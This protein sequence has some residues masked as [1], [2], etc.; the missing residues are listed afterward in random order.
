MPDDMT[1]FRMS[2]EDATAFMDRMFGNPA[3]PAPPAASAPAAG[4][5]ISP[6]ATPT[7]PPSGPTPY[8]PSNEDIDGPTD[9]MGPMPPMPTVG[10]PAGGVGG[11]AATATP[12]VDVDP[13]TGEVIER[14]AGGQPGAQ[15][16]FDP[17]AVYQDLLGS[18]PEPA[19]TGITWDD[20]GDL[21]MTAGVGMMQAGSRPGA[22]TLGAI[23]EGAGDALGRSRDIEA[24]RA[25]QAQKAQDR[26]IDLAG[27]VADY[28]V[29]G[30]RLRQSGASDEERARHNR[31]SE[32]IAEARLRL[33]EAA[34]AR[35]AA[36]GGRNEL[37]LTV[38]QQQ[39]YD[40]EFRLFL[41]SAQAN[42]IE[43]S[44]Y[45]EGG[46]DPNAALQQAIEMNPYSTVARRYAT[47]TLGA[48]LAEAERAMANGEMG[49]E[50]RAA[51]E[52]DLGY[53]LGTFPYLN[54][55]MPDL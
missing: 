15:G 21:M 25:E 29:E 30:E 26:A 48:V 38:A 34:S 46:Y 4:P 19:D 5:M 40:Q 51:L 7:T 55:F 3:S 42:A 11:G 37:G 35:A 45:N 16:A 31:H 8:I 2:S 14:P 20:A 43:A 17:M 13:E 10:A 33:S 53:L 1:S 9:P 22:T 41:N 50:D 28:S 12:V 44:I 32:A 52:A 23:G 24:S 54:D 18:I 36:G 49:E 39:A 6:P 27:K 47:Q